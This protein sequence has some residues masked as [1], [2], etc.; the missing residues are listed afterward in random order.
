MRKII[1]RLA[2][3]LAPF[4][5]VTAL[6]LP[7][8]AQADFFSQHM[9]DQQSTEL[10]VRGD[11]VSGDQ[12]TGNRYANV[13]EQIWDSAGVFACTHN[14]NPSQFVQSAAHGDGSNCPY[15]VTAL[16]DL[17]DGKEIVTL[18]SHVAQLCIL[19]HASGNGLHQGGCTT[20]RLFVKV[21]TPTTDPEYDNVLWDDSN[22]SSD[23]FLCSDGTAGHALWAGDCGSQ[24]SHWPNKA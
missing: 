11:G 6:V 2:V 22:S 1:T 17:Y 3:V 12:V 7:G 9:C 24:E 18:E 20:G 16:D 15:T 13:N 21:S 4:A 8:T 5:L 14:G 19:G 10:C 23:A